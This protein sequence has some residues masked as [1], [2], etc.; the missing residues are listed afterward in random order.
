MNQE[1]QKIEKFKIE[2]ILIPIIILII[3]QSFASIIYAFNIEKW[4]QNIIF[5]TLYVILAYNLIKVAS[6]KV[7]KRELK[8]IYIPKPKFKL[9]WIIVSII[10]PI[11]VS[12]V[13]LL[14]SGNLIKNEMNSIEI[15][16]IVT[17]AIFSVGIGA[18]VVEEIVFRGI[19][20]KSLEEWYGK[21]IAIVVPSV[22]FALIHVTNQ[23]LDFFSIILLIVAGTSVGILFSLVVYES[24]SVWN[25]VIIHGIW[26]IIIIGGILNIGEEYNKNAIFSYVLKSKEMIIT[27]GNFGIEASIVSV[28]FY[29]LFS[30]L[31][32]ILIKRKKLMQK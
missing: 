17:Y 3:S 30:L 8:D 21:K 2:N 31:A 15:L 1:I 26:N 4:I 25:S 16:N 6:L 11:S 29:V 5:G 14:M 28:V 9:V 32:Y 10:L 23:N 18:G 27:G 20:M 19:I 13:F 24:K 22:I 12:I 7:F